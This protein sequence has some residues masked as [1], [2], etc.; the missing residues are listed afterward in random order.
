MEQKVQEAEN[1]KCR[2]FADQVIFVKVHIL[3]QIKNQIT[4]R[5]ASGFFPKALIFPNFPNKFLAGEILFWTDFF[6]RVDY[7][8]T[9]ISIVYKYVQ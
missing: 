6:K 9:N 7:E 8:V 2:V 4:Y 1:L 5:L 3:N